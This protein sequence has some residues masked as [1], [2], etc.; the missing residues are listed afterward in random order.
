MFKYN[1]AVIMLWLPV[2]GIFQMPYLDRIPLLA[3]KMT[4]M[5]STS[6]FGTVLR[7]DYNFYLNHPLYVFVSF[8]MYLVL[9][10]FLCKKY[11]QVEQDDDNWFSFSQMRTPTYL[12]PNDF[13]EPMRFSGYNLLGGLDMFSSHLSQPSLWLRPSIS[14][15]YIKH[16]PTWQYRPLLL[17][18]RAAENLKKMKMAMSTASMSVSSSISNCETK[19][20]QECPGDRQSEMSNTFGTS[21]HAS[22]YERK[23]D[24]VLSCSSV[25]DAASSD[26]R[27][28]VHVCSHSQKC[29]SSN[30]SSDSTIEPIGMLNSDHEKCSSPSNPDAAVSEHSCLHCQSP[31]HDIKCDHSLTPCLTCGKTH[32]CM[33]ETHNRSISD[34]TVADSSATNLSPESIHTHPAHSEVTNHSADR[35][36]TPPCSTPLCGSGFPPGYL[37]SHQCVICLDEYAP[38]TMLCGLPCGHVFHE[39]CI[40]SWFNREKHF[41]PMCRWPSYKLHPSLARRYPVTYSS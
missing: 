35:N 34:R 32:P 25:H 29:S 9:I 13:F 38:L 15:D 1:I 7:G 11:R 40:I 22:P 19:S 4:R 39:T 14:L 17:A 33:S 16:L 41:C 12:R 18:T 10:T 28:D 3:L 8:G 31:H 24:E 5:F 36:P 21:A 2:I 37:E 26:T 27:M 20:V 30:K 6:Y 23:V